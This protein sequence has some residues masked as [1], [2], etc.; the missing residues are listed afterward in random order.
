MRPCAIT[1]IFALTDGS[2]L[3]LNAMCTHYEE[4]QMMA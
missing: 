1:I 3:I 4:E 2:N